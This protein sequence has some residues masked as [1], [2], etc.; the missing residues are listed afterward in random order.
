MAHRQDPGGVV[1]RRA[2]RVA[3]VMPVVL[4]ITVVVLGDG[5]MALYA[6]FGTFALLVFSDFAGP[7]PTR[8]AATVI[9]GVV[10]GLGVVLGTL[11]APWPWAAAG[12]AVV[13][14]FG[15]ALAGVLRG[16][17]A[18]AAAPVQLAF[19]LAATSG[20]GGWDE[21]GTRLTGWALATAV[22]AIAIVTLWPARGTSPLRARIAD[23]LDAA[24]AAVTAR[25]AD[26]GDGGD[27]AL[28]RL[29]E[30]NTALRGIY[31]SLPAR[32]GWTT[33]RDRG[34]V[35]VVEELGRL[36]AALRWHPSQ[37]SPPPPDDALVASTAST[38]GQSAAALRG[39]GPAP[40]A[41]VLVQERE[42]HRRELSTWAAQTLRTE[43]AATV[44]AGL[45]AGFVLRMTSLEAAFLA[46]YVASAVGAP[47]RSSPVTVHGSPVPSV[48]P[49]AGARQL[50]SQQL[51]LASPWLRNA[52]RSGI[53]VGLAVLVATL[54]GVSHGFWV[55]LGTVSV[56][57]FD[58][59]GTGRTA[60]QA[61]VGTVSGALAGTLVVLVAGD[62]PAVLWVLCAVAA[63]LS[64]Y[65]P[66]QISFP[67]G[68]AAFS[69]FV[70]V[71]FSLVSGPTL[72][73]GLVRVE[74]VLLGAAVSVA[75]GTLLWPRG[76][77]ARVL[78]TLADALAATASALAVSVHALAG[79]ASSAQVQAS[80]AH[81]GSQ[82]ALADETF[83]LALAQRAPA[84]LRRR[85]WGRLAAAG[86]HTLQTALLLDFLRREGTGSGHGEAGP[87]QGGAGSAPA[88]LAATPLPAAL[89]AT[90]DT[91]TGNLA[92]S[93]ARLAAL[94]AA[95][96]RD[97]AEIVLPEVDG[98]AVTRALEPLRE[99]VDATLTGWAARSDEALGD[100]VLLAC[101]SADQLAHADWVAGDARA[102]VVGLEGASEQAAA[103]VSEAKVPRWR[104]NR[105]DV[106]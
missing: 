42:E 31:R 84:R 90:V 86:V 25:W 65:T 7:L 92:G 80:V 91:V 43:G 47:D 44:R 33:E 103:S 85:A 83:D 94:P 97:E 5:V 10:G 45:D 68:Q 71:M 67:V 75:V 2:L 15:V 89:L 73:T 62:A 99:A 49:A 52:M 1:L 61:V 13:V 17:V 11:V 53:G 9:T 81:A 106:S 51:D 54:L 70:V 79:D 76:V 46:G 21:I 29:S 23:V 22:A 35:G 101:W 12:A 96:P 56:L 39:Q 24:A 37:A 48:T 4:V 30:A 58:A 63:F 57:R 6:A 87:D 27:Q 104:S 98:S 69:A 74:D 77:R 95:R 72:E 28:S 18:A 20:P 38:L 60:V 32:P 88:L 16:Y 40:D 100:D 55:V 3:V 64:A 66:T 41:A 34:I 19:V 50:L 93:A 59:L 102:A 8:S 36:T 82:V 14:G 26:G 78:A 105:K